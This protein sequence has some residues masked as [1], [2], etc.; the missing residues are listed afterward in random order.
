M[1]TVSKYLM[2]TEVIVLKVWEQNIDQSVSTSNHLLIQGQNIVSVL[3]RQVL[4]L[5]WQAFRHILDP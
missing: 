2:D 3:Q 5:A 1:Y 4:N